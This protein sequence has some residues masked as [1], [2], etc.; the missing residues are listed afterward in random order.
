ML[1]LLYICWKGGSLH[2]DVIIPIGSLLVSLWLHVCE[3]L[4]NCTF[5]RYD[6]VFGLRLCFAI[7]MHD[8]CST[9]FTLLVL[10]VL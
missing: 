7:I 6:D 5:A 8:L 2:L 1:W 4:R 9:V 10:P 3:P